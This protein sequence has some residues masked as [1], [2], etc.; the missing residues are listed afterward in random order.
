[1]RPLKLTMQAFGTYI[2]KTEIDF[3]RLGEHGL[4]LITGDTGSGK[5]TIFDGIMFALYGETSG[6]SG[7]NNMGRSGE[8]L[9]SDFAAPKEVTYVE[10]EFENDGNKYKIWRSPSYERENYKSAKPAEVKWSENGI[11]TELKTSD[12]DGK[13][14]TGV[15]GRVEEIIGLNADQFRQVAMIAQGDFRKLLTADTKARGEIFKTIFDTSIYEFIQNRINE[16]SRKAEAEFK[17][18]TTRIGGTIDNIDATDNDVLR[19]KKENGYTEI[20]SI[21]DCLLA[22]NNKD[23]GRLNQES[24]ALKKVEEKLHK[25]RANQ[26]ELVKARTNIDRIYGKYFDDYS[27][28]KKKN[29]DILSVEEE[30][31]KWQSKSV[32]SYISKRTEVNTKLQVFSQ[33][34]DAEARL[35]KLYKQYLE[36]KKSYEEAEKRVLATRNAYDDLTKKLKSIGDGKL[37]YEKC[38]TNLAKNEDGIRKLSDIKERLN[39]AKNDEVKLA[40]MKTEGNEYFLQRN[41]ANKK[42]VE[43]YTRRNSQIC[44]ELAAD[45][46]EDMPCPVCGS[47]E[48]PEKAV[49]IGMSITEEEVK[50]LQKIFD[51]KERYF[52]ESEIKINSF[53]ATLTQKKSDIVRD[54]CEMAWCE[55]FEDVSAVVDEKMS[56]LSKERNELS[57]ELRLIASKQKEYENTEKKCISLKEEI[58]K[59]EN[60]VKQK[61][62]NLKNVEKEYIGAGAALSHMKQDVSGDKE[63]L[64]AEYREICDNIEK[65]NRKKKE[66]QDRYHT[67]TNEIS[68]LK[69]AVKEGILNLNHANEAFYGYA[70][71][72]VLFD[73]TDNRNNYDEAIRVYDDL[74]KWLEDNIRKNQSEKE[75]LNADRDILNKRLAIN[76]DAEKRLQKLNKAF[77]PVYKEYNRLS[78]LNQAVLGNY[79]LET[80]IQEVYFDKIIECANRRLRQMIHNQFELRRGMKTAGVR[81][82]DLFVFD[83]RTG[84]TR[85]VKSISGGEGFVASLAMALGLADVVSSNSAGV[86]IDTLFID[87]GFG[88]LDSEILDQAIN[89]LSEISKSDHL[90]GIISH[91]DELKRRI[92]KQIVVTKDERGGSHARISGC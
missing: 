33:I 65:I 44:G 9:R 74:N 39:H 25:Y 64:E 55:S 86:R 2:E 50:K 4:F 90:V 56:V 37:E 63:Q 45:L 59:G 81:G 85:D 27:R 12:I 18:L 87:E 70:G 60:D 77:A 84:K 26:E 76:E 52:R 61:S 89:V 1:M 24:E 41:E 83:F 15:K 62:E 28:L 31:K 71:N 91:V 69:T 57:R 23:K 38:S 14:T 72:E 6:G 20:D 43:A 47:R 75:E 19:A 46:T 79:K 16:D 53:E 29:E 80:Y 35:E 82:L 22:Q 92:D 7:K 58:A 66:T 68:A 5:T 40:N 49:L 51:E 10:L 13:K 78:D 32:D 8:M 30:Y 11:D 88:S 48:H 42:Y 17:D 67:E 34:S 54:V 73:E 3:T 21:I 36:V